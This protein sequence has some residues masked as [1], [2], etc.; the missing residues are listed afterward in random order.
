[1][2]VEG[3]RVI[4][5]DDLYTTGATLSS[6]AQALLEAG[7]VEVYGLTVGRAHGDIQ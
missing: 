4:V 5:V 6:C 2:I 1:A 3:K 7:A